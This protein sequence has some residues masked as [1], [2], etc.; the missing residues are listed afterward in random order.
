M[1]IILILPISIVLLV[2]DWPK[3]TPI[4][5]TFMMSS[6]HFN[7]TVGKGYTYMTYTLC[8]TLNYLLLFVI[9]FTDLKSLYRISSQQL[10]RYPIFPADDNIIMILQDKPKLVHIAAL[11][12][13]MVHIYMPALQ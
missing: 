13:S 12:Y 1:Y 7:C 8:K 9:H 5:P 4:A 2:E 6:S 10:D 3:S 11:L